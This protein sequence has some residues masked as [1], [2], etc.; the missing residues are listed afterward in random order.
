M[1]PHTHTHTQKKKPARFH[2]FPGCT[3][4]NHGYRPI[5]FFMQVEKQKTKKNYRLD[6]CWKNMKSTS[7]TA[8]CMQVLNNPT[9]DTNF[10]PQRHTSTFFSGSFCDPELHNGHLKPALEDWAHY[11]S[12]SSHTS[13]LPPPPPP[14]KYN[15]HTHISTHTHRVVM[16]TADI[17]H[18]N[19]W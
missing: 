18:V 3:M 1:S 8:D 11:R 14:R 13:N 2:Q 15:T 16:T 10:Q 17:F 19:Q 5:W 7:K 12:S 6:A 9:T 4:N